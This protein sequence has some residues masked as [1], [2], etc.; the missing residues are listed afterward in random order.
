M[1]PFMWSLLYFVLLLFSEV[2]HAT[3]HLRAGDPQLITAQSYAQTRQNGQPMFRTLNPANHRSDYTYRGRYHYHYQA[4]RIPP[5]VVYRPVPLSPPVTYH[6]PLVPMLP[7]GHRF[8]V[9]AP[10][11][12]HHI[13]KGLSPPVAQPHPQHRIKG[14]WP[15]RLK[16]SCPTNLVTAAPVVV[17]P[18]LPESTKQPTFPAT[19]VAPVTFIMPTAS[20]V[21]TP[22]PWTQLVSTQSGLITTISPVETGVDPCAMGHDCEHIC[23]NSNAS[24]YCK[25]RNGYVL[26]ADKRTCSLKRE[27]VRAEVVEDPCK[28]E[29]MLAFQKQTQAAIQQL[30][31]KLAD[32]SGRIEHLENMLGRA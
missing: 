12:S 8:N 20:P 18:N 22:A 29:A 19:G 28:C 24:Y 13:Y 23:I 27:E 16:T 26:N 21:E 1:N 10:P 3:Y 32:I 6:R 7:Y 2:A 15:Y 17:R 30:T 4:P 5:P 25:C 14:P 9:P 11:H 31:D